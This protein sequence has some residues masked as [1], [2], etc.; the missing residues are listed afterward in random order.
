MAGAAAA[1]APAGHCMQS[2]PGAR[3]HGAPQHQPAKDGA[4]LA[5]AAVRAQYFSVERLLCGCCLP[6]MPIG[7]SCMGLP[8]GSSTAQQ[9]KH[10]LRWCGGSATPARRTCNP[11]A[12]C[13]CML[14]QAYACFGQRH[15]G[16][17]RRQ[18]A[19]Q[20][21]SSRA[22]SLESPAA[23]QR[24]RESSA[25][26]VPARLCDR[27]Q[28]RAQGP[29]LVLPPTALLAEFAVS[30]D[31]KRAPRRLIWARVDALRNYNNSE[32]CFWVARV[33]LALVRGLLKCAANGQNQ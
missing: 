21:S 14:R 17:W 2:R 28:P 16:S 18:P 10:R 1:A 4:C 3:V 9:S 19:G 13:A 26:T 5:G 6:S 30:D 31:L 12:C 8:E 25:Y 27:G 32:E 33:C 20:A 23:G 7:R 22:A 11:A 29:L 15:V 24:P